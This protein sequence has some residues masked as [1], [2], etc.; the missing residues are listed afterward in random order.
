MSTTGMKA[1]LTE[2]V[3][4]RQIPIARLLYAFGI[5]LVSTSASK[6]SLELNES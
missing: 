6:F 5:S 4:V 1:F 3:I 2:Y